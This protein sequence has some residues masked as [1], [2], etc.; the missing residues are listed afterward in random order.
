MPILNSI[1]WFGKCGLRDPSLWVIAR[2]VGCGS[3][4]L[5]CWPADLVIRA[6][7]AIFLVARSRTSVLS[8][9]W[10]RGW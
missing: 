1:V 3:D 9:V 4:P 6:E 2:A 8:L 10:L 5:R 7:M